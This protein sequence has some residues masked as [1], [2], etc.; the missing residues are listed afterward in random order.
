M[1][2]ASWLRSQ[3]Q[4][5]GVPA[6]GRAARR[7]AARADR[8]PSRPRLEAL[9][10]RTLLSPYLVTTTADSGPGSLRDAIDQVNA[11]TTSRYAPAAL[12]RPGGAT[13][14]EIDFAVTAGSDT[15]GGYDP[16]TGVCT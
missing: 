5:G 6:R 2:F 8:V 9:E 14:D 3:K 7:P 10:E 11:D 13:V 12:N 4:R 16:T 15:G 1:A